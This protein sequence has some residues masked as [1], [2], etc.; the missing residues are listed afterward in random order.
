M[1][2]KNVTQIIKTSYFYIVIAVSMLFVGSGIGM[3]FNTALQYYFFPM[4]ER[5]GYSQC[6]QE[7]PMYYLSDKGC[8]NGA[9]TEEQ[10]ATLNNLIRDYETWKTQNSGEVCFSAQRQKS[11]VDALTMLFV[12]S[13][14]LIL[15]IFLLKKQKAE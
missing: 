5:G 12:A 8:M 3:L 2:M 9:T 4:A 11:I 15:H 10:Q 13:P 14:I 1:F 7:P 6:T